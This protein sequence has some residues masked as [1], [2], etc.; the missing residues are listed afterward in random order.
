MLLYEYLDMCAL[1]SCFGFSCVR[2]AHFSSMNG[3]NRLSTWTLCHVGCWKSSD[4]APFLA[5]YSAYLQILATF[6][7]G[8]T[9]VLAGLFWRPGVIPPVGRGEGGRSARLS[10]RAHFAADARYTEAVWMRTF[11]SSPVPWLRTREIARWIPYPDH[12]DRDQD[13]GDR[14]WRSKWM[15]RT[16][17]APC[18]VFF[19]SHWLVLWAFLYFYR[20]RGRR[21][22]RRRPARLGSKMVSTAFYSPMSCAV[23]VLYLDISVLWQTAIYADFVSV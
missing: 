7:Y 15:W 22:H 20:G 5:T 9:D 12:C 2:M 10:A 18:S 13:R 17:T 23:L 4:H 11:I 16:G 3:S 19:L 6:P 8:S 14:R 1:W 21:T